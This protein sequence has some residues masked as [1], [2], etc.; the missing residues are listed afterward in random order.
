MSDFWEVCLNG[1][2]SARKHPPTAEIETGLTQ[3]YYHIDHSIIL[4]IAYLNPLTLTLRNLASTI[5]LSFMNC[6]ISVCIYFRIVKSYTVRNNF[7][8]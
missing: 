3:I 6:L 4:L 1:V 2:D 8:N 5:R 7:V